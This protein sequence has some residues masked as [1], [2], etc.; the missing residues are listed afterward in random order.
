MT[1]NDKWTQLTTTAQPRTHMHIYSQTNKE[2]NPVKKNNVFS[3]LACIYVRTEKP[4]MCTS[5]CTLLPQCTHSTHIN[6]FFLSLFHFKRTQHLRTHNKAPGKRSY[7]HSIFHATSIPFRPAEAFC[8]HI[9]KLLFFPNLSLHFFVNVQFPGINYF[10][11]DCLPEK[12][13]WLERR[14]FYF[15]EPR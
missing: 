7:F 9:Y 13:Y 2:K 3:S 6:I 15:E 10:F 1:K 5:L 4:L 8:V 11:P 12:K 14:G